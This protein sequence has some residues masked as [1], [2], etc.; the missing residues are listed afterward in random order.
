MPDADPTTPFDLPPRLAAKADPTLIAADVRHFALLATTLTTSVA[1]LEARLDVVR[2]QPGGV[3]EEALTRDLEVHRLTSRLRA[4]SRYGLDLCLGRMVPAGATDDDA[5]HVGRFG[6]TDA[7]GRRVLVDWRSPAAEPFFAATHAHPAGLA[8]RR[9]YRW[10]GGRITDYWDE[11]F[12][13]DP[14]GPGGSAASLDDQSA[15]VASLGASRS[16]QMR[17]VLATIQ[18]DQDAIIRAGSRGT[19][20]VDGGPG[21]GKTVVALHRAAYLLHADRGSA[22]AAGACCSSARTSP[23]CPTWP[24]CCRASARRGSARAPCG[25]S[26]P[27]ARTPPRRPTPTW[28]ASRPIPGW[29]P[30]SSRRSRS[31][32]SRRPRPSRSRRRGPTSG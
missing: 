26:S 9:R 32:R 20:V 21:T 28:L 7:T 13:D 14:A 8:S 25:T 18:A 4:L 11:V 19:L 2:R 12:A 31:T 5:V 6:L 10:S 16:P 27:R 3:G 23:T 30:P 29:S 15:F 17:D 1:E 22:R 24:T